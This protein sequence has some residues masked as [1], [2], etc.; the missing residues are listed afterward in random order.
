MN[1]GIINDNVHVFHYITT[2][3]RFITACKKSAD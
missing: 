2:Y 1:F 3:Y